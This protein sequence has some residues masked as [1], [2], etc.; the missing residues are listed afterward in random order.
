MKARF[1]AW[2]LAA[3]IWTRRH[4]SYVFTNGWTES[5]ITF[6]VSVTGKA[7]RWVKAKLT[8]YFTHNLR[9][10]MLDEITAAKGR[11]GPFVQFDEESLLAYET[12]QRSQSTVGLGGWYDELPPGGVIHRSLVDLVSNDE[13]VRL[14][15]PS[16][17]QLDS[18]L[19]TS[20]KDWSRKNR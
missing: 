8:P 12:A 2:R 15:A 20:L 7:E 11:P 13:L 18:S 5:R 9:Q 19:L 17:P 14:H 10:Q 6:T 3:R 1:A 4:F 16:R